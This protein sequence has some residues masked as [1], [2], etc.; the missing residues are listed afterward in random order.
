MSDLQIAMD[1]VGSSA[2]DRIM[3]IGAT[4][5][6]WELDE[7]VLRCEVVLIATLP[8]QAKA[9]AQACIYSAARPGNTP[10]YHREEHQQGGIRSHSARHAR[11]C[12]V[13]G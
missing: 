7:A 11:D 9:T 8:H 10:I 12:A 4:N 3:M 13:C 5:L 2:E 6:P 1:G